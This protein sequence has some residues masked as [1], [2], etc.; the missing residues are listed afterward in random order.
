MA[1]HMKANFGP[2][3]WIGEWNGAVDD[4]VFQDDLLQTHSIRPEAWQMQFV[5]Q[6][7]WN[8]AV[9]FIG[10]QGTYFVVGYSESQDLGGVTRVIGVDQARVGFVPRKRFLIGLG[11]WVLDGLRVATEYSHAVDYDVIDG[12]TGNTADSYFVQLTYEW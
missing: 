5:Y 7:D 8:P 1:A 6:F 9:E 11:E 10:L 4:A 12:G 2:T 3:S